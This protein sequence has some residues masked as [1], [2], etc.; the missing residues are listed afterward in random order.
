[1]TFSFTISGLEQFFGLMLAINLVFFAIGMF[2]ATIFLKVTERFAEKIFGEQGLKL[3]NQVPQILM[4]Y[5]VLIIIFNLS[6]FIVLK[7]LQWQS[8]H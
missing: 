6:P 7:I 1:M 2:K 5:W 8:G 4:F 3:I